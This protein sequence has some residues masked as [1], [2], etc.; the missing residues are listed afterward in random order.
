MEPTT[1]LLAAILAKLRTVTA[2][3]ALTGTRIYDN[4]P[5][6]ANAPTS[7]YVSCDGGD[8]LTDDADCIESYEVTYQI[9]VWSWGVGE[10]FSSVQ[11][12]KIAHEIKK[13]LHEQDLPLTTNALVSIRHNITRYLRDNDNA[14]NH[15]AVS[16]TAIVEG[17]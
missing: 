16:V 7:P 1:E 11:V 5:T 15:A 3:T 17:Q 14:V 12:R 8:A 6:G 10:A 9:D 4:V 2:I 13:A